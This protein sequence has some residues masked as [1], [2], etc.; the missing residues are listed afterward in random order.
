MIILRKF[1]IFEDFHAKPTV[2]YHRITYNSVLRSKV[3]IHMTV[4]TQQ[5]SKE[6]IVINTLAKMY[7]KSKY[8][9]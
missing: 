1:E 6:V 4:R 3:N 2:Y 9:I 5:I 8:L 7:N